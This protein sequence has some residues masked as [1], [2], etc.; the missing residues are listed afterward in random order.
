MG[1]PSV[2]GARPDEQ[3]LLAYFHGRI[4]EEDLI[5]LLERR[6]RQVL[7]G[8]HAPTPQ[9]NERLRQLQSYLLRDF[10]ESL[11][12][13]ADTLRQ[14]VR[15][16]RAFEQAL[17]GD[18]SP[19]SLAEQVLQAFR[20]GR[21]SPTAAAFQFVELIR[22]VAGLQLEADEPLCEAEREVLEDVRAQGLA[23][24]LVLATGAA[25]RPDFRHACEDNDFSRYVMASLPPPV[26]LQWANA[27]L[28]GTTTVAEPPIPPQLEDAI[29]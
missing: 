12:G 5:E 9:E 22:A 17:V 11:F 2:L 16:P 14:S 6:V 21:R 10:V 7:T 13:L 19:R 8:G 20:A 18:F 23:R 27:V 29:P 25:E 1:L 26:A 15:S 28:N 3:Q 24:L 4:S